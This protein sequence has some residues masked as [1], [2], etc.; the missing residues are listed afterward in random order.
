MMA[1][2]NSTW[3]E[4]TIGQLGEVVTGTTPPTKNPE[5]YGNEYP[6]ITVFDKLK[7]THL[8]EL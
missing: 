7:G 4:T 8:A 3:Y 1:G 6:F 2:Q 5:F